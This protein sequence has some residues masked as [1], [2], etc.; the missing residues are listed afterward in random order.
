MVFIFDG[1][2]SVAN[3]NQ[4]FKE[5][6]ASLM[7]SKQFNESW[8]VA[9]LVTFLQYKENTELTLQSLVRTLD[10][11]K[12]IRISVLTNG[13]EIE[14]RESENFAERAVEFLNGSG[15]SVELQVV[16]FDLPAP[17]TRGYKLIDINGNESNE[18]IAQQIV[19]MS[20][21]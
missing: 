12:Q 19:S 7:L 15:Y 18:F 5:N 17:K 9:H 6:I 21:H 14:W 2:S 20:L 16:R 8:P 13:D 1:Y 4:H 10:A 3:Q 11:T